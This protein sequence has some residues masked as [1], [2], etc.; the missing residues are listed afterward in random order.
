MNIFLLFISMFIMIGYYI[1]SSPSQNIAQQETEFVIQQ[2]DIR[3]IAE[4][5]VNTQNAVMYCEDFEDECVERYGIT[6]KYV[7]IDQRNA[8]TGS[9]SM[10]DLCASTGLDTVDFADTNFIMTTSYVLPPEERNNML[11]I[12]EKYYS[13]RGTLGIVEDSKLIVPDSVV[14][15]EIPQNVIRE[16]ELQDGQL[17]YIMQYR[18][19]D[20]LGGVQPV[21]DDPEQ[22]DCPEGYAAINRFGRWHCVP[23][24]PLI[25]C[26]EYTEWSAETQECEPTEE[27]HCESENATLVK[28]DDNWVC[29]EPDADVDC[30]DGVLMFNA[31]TLGWDCITVDNPGQVIE[32]CNTKKPGYIFSSSDLTKVNK[33]L[34]VKTVSCGVCEKP[35]MNPDTCEVYCLPDVSKLNTRSCFSGDPT[36]CTGTNKGIYFGFTPKSRTEGLVGEDGEPI[37]IVLK[38]I[39]DEN[40]AQN[41]KFNCMECKYSTLKTSIYPYVAICSGEEVQTVSATRTA[42]NECNWEVVDDDDWSVLELEKPQ[43][44]DKGT[45]TSQSGDGITK[46]DAQDGTDDEKTDVKDEEQSKKET[47]GDAQDGTDDEKTGVKDEEQ[48]K[49]ETEEDEKTKLETTDEEKPPVILGKKS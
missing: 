42:S 31:S 5:V 4:C 14:A 30:A 26:Q 20:D 27:F 43:V 47:E 13:D 21:G 25:H 6:S 22:P 41:K 8:V 36:C 2:S 24:N 3:S 23:I 12:L 32:N 40:H 19:P 34:K 35:Y 37:D 15:R 33:T 10:E 39:L 45:G 9:G 29:L 17:A 46:I 28:I 11:D 18:I 38:D 44:M 48:S 49:K 7:F 1:M 16:A